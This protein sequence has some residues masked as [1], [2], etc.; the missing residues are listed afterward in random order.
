VGGV[1]NVTNQ[2]HWLDDWDATRSGAVG[3]V[4][5]RLLRSDASPT[6]DIRLRLYRDSNLP[7]GPD[8]MPGTPTATSPT[9]IPAG[10]LATN[11]TQN[12]MFFFDPGTTPVGQP[13]R[14]WWWVLDLSGVTNFDKVIVR[15]NPYNGPFRSGTT[16]QPGLPPP[17]A[18]WR[19][20]VFDALSWDDVN[21][22]GTHSLGCM[23]GNGRQYL[24]GGAPR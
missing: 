6:G 7:A 5:L 8:A 18:S 4:H 2:K 23:V 14:K 13:A 11:E 10:E 3:A 19:C 20:R 16:G 12:V 17:A 21:G 15:S 9:V 22:H 1:G 24:V